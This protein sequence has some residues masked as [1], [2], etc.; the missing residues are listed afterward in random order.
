MVFF[1]CWFVRLRVRTALVR[2]FFCWFGCLFVFSSGLCNCSPLVC[3]FVCLSACVVGSWLVSQCLFKRLLVCLSVCL[4]V[5]LFL[6]LST[7]LSLCLFVS[8]SAS[9]WF[10]NGWFVN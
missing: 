2:S 7:G 1:V 9:A 10:F 6:S 4:S 5:C 8:L 3:L